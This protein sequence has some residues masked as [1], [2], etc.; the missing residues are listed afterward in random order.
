MKPKKRIRV[1]TAKRLRLPASL[2]GRVE[3]K[4]MVKNFRS[5]YANGGGAAMAKA[6][7][8]ASKMPVETD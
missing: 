7:E 2:K 1:T 3:M 6:R 5:L 8:R 4:K